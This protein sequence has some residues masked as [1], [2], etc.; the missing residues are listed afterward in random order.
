MRERHERKEP[1]CYKDRDELQQS[2]YSEGW[3]SDGIGG[4][5]RV[6]RFRDGSSTYHRGGPCGDQHSDRYGNEC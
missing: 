1:L 3:E 2:D 6:T 5:V 4:K